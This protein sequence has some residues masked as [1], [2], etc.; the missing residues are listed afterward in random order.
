MKTKVRPEQNK[1]TRWGI[2]L[3]MGAAMFQAYHMGRAFHIYDPEGWNIGG[4]NVG[5]LIL[6]GILNVIVAQ[7]AVHL[8]GISAT[9]AS[10]KELMP[11]ATKKADKKGEQARS[12]AMKKMLLAMK[13]NVYSQVGFYI[14]LVF[15]VIMI[16]PALYILWSHTLPFA[17]LFIAFMAI[18]VAVSPDV[19]IT[20]GG[21]IAS[22]ARSDAQ[23]ASERRPATTSDA[24]SDAQ[25][26]KQRRSAMAPAA[27]SVAPTKLYRCECGE[28]FL[29]RFV[30]SGH[31]GKCTT[32]KE[33]KANKLIPV[34]FST[35]NK[36]ERKS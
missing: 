18:V 17:K 15:S 36:V 23:R 28:E 10:L 32:R 8:P 11:K 4:V 30:Y 1:P 16:A 9:F 5:G 7:A 22:D 29:D 21:F 13:Q 3:V 26:P 14:L 27:N 24:G 25:R 19:A 35:A 2:L 31:A 33:I 20:V 12:R 34:D 6:G